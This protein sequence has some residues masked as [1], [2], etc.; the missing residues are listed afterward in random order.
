MSKS[1]LLTRKIF[2]GD[3]HPG[4]NPDIRFYKVKDVEK[5]DIGDNWLI[6][7]KIYKA[8]LSTNKNNKKLTF[9]VIKYFYRQGPR[10]IHV[11]RDMRVSI[12]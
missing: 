5:S 6:H 7:V 10:V 4:F 12:S 9:L 3:K 2:S 8:S 11:L 1:K